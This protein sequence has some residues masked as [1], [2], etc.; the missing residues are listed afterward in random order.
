MLGEAKI[1]GS[2]LVRPI[3]KA[4][5]EK[6]VGPC[7]AKSSH[8]FNSAVHEFTETK[9]TWAVP[10]VQVEGRH[11]CVQESRVGGAQSTASDVFLKTMCKSIERGPTTSITLGQ[12]DA[13]CWYSKRHAL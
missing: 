9:I 13:K 1:P 7:R 12:K 3:T 8:Q 6:R 10:S 5:R 4:H 11:N 2:E